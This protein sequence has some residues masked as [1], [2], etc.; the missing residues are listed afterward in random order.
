VNT[1]LAAAAAML[2]WLVVEKIVTGHGTT[3]GA[4]SGAVAGLVAIT[5]C[6]GYVGGAAPVII[7]AGAG[8]V[9]YLAL[10][11]KGLL[12]L[13][14][15]LDVIAVHLVGGL[16]GS[17]VLGLFAD[18]SATG[19]GVDG[20]FFGGGSELLFD[21]LVASGSV[22]IFS[23]VVS[24]I[25]AVAIDKTIGMRVQPDDEYVGLDRSQHA[26]SAYQP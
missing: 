14:D 8:V 18:A 6:A 22:L 12:R 16:F 1:H 2:G 9:C 10:R 7:G 25:I 24:Y 26:E 21:Q 15:S 11:L 23:L 4:A 5:P 3:L 19:I 13:D 17:I 20:L